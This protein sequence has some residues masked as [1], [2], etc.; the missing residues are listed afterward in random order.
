MLDIHTHILPGMDDGSRSV[1]MSLEMLREQARQGVDTVVCTSHFYAE[2]NDPL[3]FLERRAAA[4]QRLQAALTPDLPEIR[5]GAEVQYF[6]GISRAEHIGRL[7]IQGTNLLLLEMPF[8][9]WPEFAV[10]EAIALNSREDTQ[11]VLA[12]IERYFRWQPKDIVERMLS[13]GF[14][15]QTNVSFFTDWKT[16]HRALTMLRRGQIHLIASDCHN[17]TTRRPCLG[18]LPGEAR[19]YMEDVGLVNE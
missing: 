10:E 12:H 9:K 15:I 19:A 6:T 5:L 17:M 7:R 4:W 13:E 2:Q 18:E 11:V 8:C 14:L 3:R 1:E 16:R